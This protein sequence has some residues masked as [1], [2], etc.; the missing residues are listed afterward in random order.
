MGSPQQQIGLLDGTRVVHDTVDQL[1]VDLLVEPVNVIVLPGDGACLFHIPVDE[2]QQGSVKHVPRLFGHD[3]QVDERLHQRL[4]AD[5]Q[6]D[7]SDALGIVAHALQLGTDLQDGSQKT[8]VAG[9]G[10]LGRNE[11]QDTVLDGKASLVDATVGDDEQPGA[12]KVPLLEQ[13]DGLDQRLFDLAAQRQNLVLEALQ[14][15]IICLAHDFVLLQS[16]RALASKVALVCEFRLISTGSFIVPASVNMTHSQ[17][18]VT[19]SA[20]RFMP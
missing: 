10:R 19:R 20:A 12:G 18:P 3:R 15:L 1:A 17:M 9:H 4:L 13:L 14:F 16:Y 8:H 11:G 2:G 5:H 6:V 7:A